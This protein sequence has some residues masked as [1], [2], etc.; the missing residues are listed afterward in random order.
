MKVLI[1]ED[2][3]IISEDICMILESHGYEVC[4]QA[5]D[6]DD[7]IKIYK[8]NRPDIV[9]LDINLNGSKDGIE[10]AKSMNALGRVPF[11]YTSSLSDAE[12]IRRAKETQPSTYI[13]K[14]FQ[15]EQL[16]AAIEVAVFNFSTKVNSDTK[17]EH[18]AIFN[19]AIFVKED[20]RFR[21]IELSTIKYVQKS[22]NY[23]ELFTLKRKYLIRGTIGGFLDHIGNNKFFQTHRSFVINMDYITDV[24][25]T[26]VHLGEIEIPLSKSFAS[27]LMTRLNIF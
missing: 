23:L 1:V 20:N 9:L 4:G 8:N 21:K 2:E 24:A 22:D 15:E 25:P 14:P 11:I 19:D 5:T 27:E 26:S 16:V 10:V 3:M 12:T 17:E 6:Y 13:V 7:A 18:L